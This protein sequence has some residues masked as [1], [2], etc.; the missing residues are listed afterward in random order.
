[1]KR[2]AIFAA[3]LALGGAAAGLLLSRGGDGSESSPPTTRATTTRPNPK[4]KPKPRTSL[5]SWPLYGYDPARTHAAPPLDLHPPF[6]KVWTVRGDWSLVEFPPVLEHGRLFVGTN[7]GLVLAV[8]AATGRVLWHRQFAGCVAASPAVGHGVVYLGFMDPPPCTG[9]APSFVA[10][11]DARSGRTF[12]RCARQ[13]PRALCSSA[14]RDAST[15]PA[16]ARA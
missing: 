11:L 13:H 12:W 1:M 5:G 4:P 2:V 9:T 10:A 7:H 3:A 14:K 6:R 8:Q 15:S 16:S